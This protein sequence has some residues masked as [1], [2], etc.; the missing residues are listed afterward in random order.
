[1]SS[2]KLLLFMLGV[3][4]CSMNTVAATNGGNQA[5]PLRW[6]YPEERFIDTAQFYK[7]YPKVTVIDARTRFEWETLRVKGSIN[8][9]VDEINTG[10]N[11]QFEQDLR[12]E[13]QTDS[14]P[15]VFY[16][17]GLTCPKSYEAA[18]RAIRIG[19]TNVYTYDAGIL[20]WVKAHPDLSLLYGQGPVDPADLISVAQFKAHV[21]PAKD[22][23]SRIRRPDCRCIVL[24][25]RD[26]AQEDFTLFP[27]HDVHVTL[28]NKQLLDAEIEKAKDSNKALL[29]Y[30]AVGKQV[31]WLQ[32]YLVKHGLKD[33]YFMKNGENGYVATIK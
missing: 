25:V 13:R 24:D 32:Y 14:K 23:I 7:M 4:A 6:R 33:Y 3:V 28:D 9:P 27:M 5:F 21:L 12:K 30:D 1:M 20:A 15:I 26:L 16:C 10:F 11:M 31:P 19:V 8:I 22:F 18:R 29:A 2:R 17:N